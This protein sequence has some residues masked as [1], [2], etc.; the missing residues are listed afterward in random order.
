MHLLITHQKRIGGSSPCALL[1]GFF[2][3]AFI[4]IF[5]RDYLG[6]TI[7]IQC[8]RCVGGLEDKDEEELNPWSLETGSFGYLAGYL[9]GEKLTN[10]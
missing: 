10:F 4:S 8:E 5:D 1:V 6:T 2:A 9:E 7:T 3:L